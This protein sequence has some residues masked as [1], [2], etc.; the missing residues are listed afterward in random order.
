[1]YSAQSVEIVHTG[2]VTISGLQLTTQLYTVYINTDR[3][4]T[5]TSRSY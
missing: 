3:H 5:N 4:N 1:M 2:K